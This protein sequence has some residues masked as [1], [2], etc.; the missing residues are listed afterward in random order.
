MDAGVQNAASREEFNNETELNVINC[1][2]L[3]L[4]SSICPLVQFVRNSYGMPSRSA[5][6]KRPGS[7]CKINMFCGNN[8]VR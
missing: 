4:F 1:F 5:T 2:E 8:L 6:S 3:G 7:R